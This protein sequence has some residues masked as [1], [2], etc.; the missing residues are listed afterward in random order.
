MADIASLGLE[1]DGK[2]AFITL[3][4]YD[5]QLKKTAASGKKL[6]VSQKTLDA[7]MKVAAQGN[8]RAFITL[9]QLDAEQKKAAAA[10]AVRA[11]TIRINN[12]AMQERI[13][14][15]LAIVEAAH[16]EAVA[17]NTV[18]VASTNASAGVG[19]LNLTMAS[20]LTRATATTPVLAQLGL[21]IGSFA[22]GSLVMLPVLAGLAA[23]GFAFQALRRNAREATEEMERNLDVLRQLRDQ[24]AL[25]EAGGAV[26]VGVGEAQAESRRLASFLRNIVGAGGD[27]AEVQLLRDRTI[28]QLR[29]S[30]DLIRAGITEIEGAEAAAR[31]RKRREDLNLRNDVKDATERHNRELI[32]IEKERVDAVAQLAR[33]EDESRI[34]FLDRATADAEAA[35]QESMRRARDED[36]FLQILRQQD[37]DAHEQA[38]KDKLEATKKRLEEERDMMRKIRLFAQGL[39]I[40]GSAVGG[41]VG[42]TLGG[43]GGGV[44]TGASAGAVLG[45]PGG[46]IPGL[47][48]GGVL[49]G[50]GGLFSSLRGADDERAAINRANAERRRRSRAQAEARMIAQAEEQI[51]LLEDQVSEQQRMVE[52]LTNVIDSLDDF[53][54]SLKLS[55]LSPLSPAQQLAEARAQFEAVRLL[56]LGGDVSAAES[57]PASARALLEASRAFNASGRG[58]VTD[59]NL[60]QATLDAVRVQFEE[61][62]TIEQQMLD[63][64][65]RLRTAA[66]EELAI[67]TG[68]ADRP[69]GGTGGTDAGADDPEGRDIIRGFVEVVDERFDDLVDAADRT[70]DAVNRETEVEGARR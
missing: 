33:D 58:F 1:V 53:S 65:I 36:E 6:E 17:M 61:Q 5:E 42:S 38:E 56:A 48:I 41:P 44:A 19:R 28:K 22:V 60:V 46:V 3:K 40:L 16:A 24:Q 67:L 31:A 51:R 32:Q 4:E 25:A 13:A 55:N 21:A 57:L 20:L 59:F 27:E 26:A 2:R 9:A 30:N 63:E 39:G 23:L 62:R 50:I 54:D 12:I 34:I 37:I 35:A 43:I 11:R 18:A 52:T 15:E 10:E 7:Q 68:G 69:G 66:E 29:E 64:L 14:L 70:T 49:G 45:G 8:R 47:I